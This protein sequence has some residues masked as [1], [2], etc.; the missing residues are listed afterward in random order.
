[1]RADVVVSARPLVRLG[2]VMVKPKKRR[3]VARRYFLSPRACV[4]ILRRAAKRR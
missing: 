2:G 4:G 3:P 1:M